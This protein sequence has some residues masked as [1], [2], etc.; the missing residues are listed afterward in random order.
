MQGDAPYSHTFQSAA[1]SGLGSLLDSVGL[2][3]LKA[4]LPWLVRIVSGHTPSLPW[5]A[6]VGTNMTSY[7]VAMSL[8]RQTLSSVAASV[9]YD[10]TRADMRQTLRQLVR[11][12]SSYD[13]WSSRNSARYADITDEIERQA[14][15]RRGYDSY[16]DLSAEGLAS[17]PFM[18]QIYSALAPK[19]GLGDP[20]AAS[21]GMSNLTR[22]LARGRFSENPR[23]ATSVASTVARG[24]LGGEVTVDPSGYGVNVA[25]REF[26]PFD[27]AGF[28]RDNVAV[29]AAARTR[30]TDLLS[31]LDI[32]T[33]QGLKSGVDRL[34]DLMKG[35]VEALAPLR[36]VFGTDIPKM[37]QTLEGLTGQNFSSISQSRLATLSESI[38][39]AV[40][41]GV[42]VSDI[43]SQ[44]AA[45]AKSMAG[46]KRPAPVL[47]TDMESM[48]LAAASMMG[49]G[50]TP[51]GITAS[52]WRSAASHRALS[53]NSSTGME[54]TRL[55]YSVWREQRLREEPERRRELDNELQAGMK[56]LDEA[57]ASGALSE[58]QYQALRHQL[59]RRHRAAVSRVAGVDEFSQELSER[60]QGG[61]TLDA[62]LR[63]MTGVTDLSQ[64]ERGRAFAGYEMAGRGVALTEA[65]GGIDA[66]SRARALAER[67]ASSAQFQRALGT[68]DRK[69][70]LGVAIA[71]A[72]AYRDIPSLRTADTG[73]YERV[74]REA[75]VNDPDRVAMAIRWMRTENQDSLDTMVRL[76]QA[77]NLRQASESQTRSSTLRDLADMVPL[78]LDEGILKAALDSGFNVDRF[79]RRFSGRRELIELSTY[80]GDI[81][82]VVA[83]A[84]ARAARNRPGGAAPVTA[85]ELSTDISSLMRYASTTTDAGFLQA[86]N[87]YRAAYEELEGG[88]ADGARAAELNRVMDRASRMMWSQAVVGSDLTGKL[89]GA[90]GEDRASAVI[91][92]LLGARTRGAGE[93]SRMRSAYSRYILEEGLRKAPASQAVQALAVGLLDT[94]YRSV[95]AYDRN[96]DGALDVGEGFSD[97]WKSV[98]SKVWDTKGNAP[99]GDTDQARASN[100]QMYQ[101]LEL[102]REQL[103]ALDNATVPTAFSS[104]LGPLTSLLEQLVQ[105]MSSALPALQTVA[106]N[107]TG[108]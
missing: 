27:W 52:Q 90:L 2:S 19:L 10:Y 24:L 61:E 93:K 59:A 50:A 48:G 101:A 12:F 22:N 49:T 107:G 42:N 15:M 43:A 92:Q 64:L 83:D 58:D 86:L 55:A 9:G 74:L 80:E 4:L 94:Y 36:D 23:L 87:E 11:A 65:I 17:K 73:D 99:L 41:A 3:D 100:R 28:S 91:G 79:K 70:A 37:I 89:I 20:A 102:V 95:D 34:R 106:A 75:G 103:S 6:L 85:R 21:E 39:N 18:P 44:T 71:A 5:G 77:G 63:G 68:S 69:D 29:L 26:S 40:N 56:T 84:T 25:P 108:K 97:F 8:Q 57:K 1:T 33:G 47:Y 76:A 105:L 67:L 30:G 32:T 88:G 16:V 104:A 7:G 78:L 45:V 14:A 13:D 60:V 72:R 96:G 31:G 98:S 66:S 46:L 35:T 51:T 53:L 62:A 38:S 81:A 82:A 54:Y